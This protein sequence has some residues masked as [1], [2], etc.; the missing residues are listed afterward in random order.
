MRNKK[1]GVIFGLLYGFSAFLLMVFFLL[2][3]ALV[4]ITSSPYYENLFKEKVVQPIV[5]GLDMKTVEVVWRKGL[6]Q[7]KLRQLALTADSFLLHME[8]ASIAVTPLLYARGGAP[9]R[10]TLSNGTFI[11]SGTTAGESLPGLPKVDIDLMDFLISSRSNP[12]LKF[13]IDQGGLSYRNHEYAIALQG[14]IFHEERRIGDIRSIARFERELPLM[15]TFYVEGEDFF[16]SESRM[17]MTDGLQ[18]PQPLAALHS[19]EGDAKLWGNMTRGRI[20]HITADLSFPRTV[21]GAAREMTIRDLRIFGDFRHFPSAIST[22]W[23]WY[24]EK[25]SFSHEG[26]AFSFDRGRV[27]KRDSI[28]DVYIPKLDGGD[29]ASLLLP[30]IRNASTREQLEARDPSGQL[31]ELRVRLD[32][33]KKKPSF[34][35]DSRLEDVSM[36]PYGGA[37]GF[38]GIRGRLHIEDERGWF[39]LDSANSSL[40]IANLYE[41]PFLF[42]AARGF[43]AWEWLAEK[44][45]LFVGDVPF[46]HTEQ[47]SAS[48]KL[49]L[50]IVPFRHSY[51]DLLVG[52]RNSR[53]ELARSYIPT[54][55]MSDQVTEW[56]DG[57]LQQARVPQ[58]A[59]AL[60]GDL[61]YFDNS[62]NQFELLV[63]LEDAS[64]KHF[65]KLPPLVFKRASF[66]MDKRT[67]EVSLPGGGTTAG[68]GTLDRAAVRFNMRELDLHIKGEGAIPV[69]SLSEVLT[70]YAGEVT[71]TFANWQLEG[72]LNGSWGLAYRMGEGGGLRNLSFDVRLERGGLRLPFLPRAFQEG[73]G[74]IGFSREGG[75]TGQVTARLGDERVAAGFVRSGDRNVLRVR[76]WADPEDYVPPEL[77]EQLSGKSFVTARLSRPLTGG[78]GFDRLELET[79]LRGT[80]LKLPAPLTKAAAVNRP[81]FYQLDFASGRTKHLVRMLGTGS[82]GWQREADIV[83][84]VFVNL[85]PSPTEEPFDAMVVRLDSI[86]LTAWSDMVSSIRAAYAI[87]TG[88]PAEKE[89]M[90]PADLFRVLT[91]LQEQLPRWD[92]AIGNAEW[93]GKVYQDVRLNYEAARSPWVSFSSRNGAGN[94]LMNEDSSQIHFSRLNFIGAASRNESALDV[95]PRELPWINFAD[96]PDLFISIANISY[97]G[98]S[99]GRVDLTAN[100]TDDAMVIRPAALILG[101]P[102]NGQVRWQSFGTRRSSLAFDVSGNGALDRQLPSVVS[103]ETVSFS[104]G[105]RW[106]GRNEEFGRW[107]A[108]TQGRIGL[109]MENGLLV[110]RQTSVLVNLFDLLNVNNLLRRLRGDF[111]DISEERLDFDLIDVD[112]DLKDGRLSI[113]ER[114]VA[115]L[116]FAEISA[117][118][119]YDLVDRQVNYDVSVAAPVTNVLPVTALLLGISS[120]TPLLL[121]LDIVGSDFFTRFSTAVYK[122]EGHA[123]QPEIK[124]VRIGDVQGGEISEQELL[125]QIDVQQPLR[126]LRF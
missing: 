109:T 72:S 10:A 49:S 83:R 89:R 54:R 62:E 101:I 65:A 108:R 112:M 20:T 21:M 121:S 56:L 88:G 73:R 79:F 32:A 103:S 60:H 45:L 94:F 47:Q 111:S 64:F 57:A 28:Y 30:F 117:E 22:G 16:L 124:L 31:R 75:Y 41:K 4:L 100:F 115:Q 114:A 71:D 7:F 120:L 76:G 48:M 27:V 40:F 14:S 2:Q 26:R 15:G 52:L 63:D 19:I 61:N 74:R 95:L 78:L 18:L 70:Q 86:N 82:F 9:Y 1:P 42:D 104:I 97:D 81:L 43:F 44:E 105:L 39:R 34:R 58:A 50:H 80:Q 122:V 67:I 87:E 69:A 12:R 98:K 110:S 102:I 36:A 55:I 118:G 24:F 68:V 6:P 93:R 33:R 119:Y 46:L 53:L 3:T 17:N 11:R 90:V 99:L 92:I 96:M 37:P 25:A 51:I 85:V 29:L 8:E 116:S 107:R 23:T 66:S 77:Q 113:R 125:N 126:N 5:P 59:M 91:A 84:D 13:M 106:Q 35:L 38:T 123:T